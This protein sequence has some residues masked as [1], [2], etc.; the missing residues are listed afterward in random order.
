V[1]D[2][3]RPNIAVHK[4]ASVGSATIGQTFSY[5]VTASNIGDATAAAG[6][7]VEDVLPSEVDFVSANGNNG[8]TCVH[9]GS[10]SGG[11]VTCTPTALAPGE[12]ETYTIEVRANSTATTA[13]TNTA[14]VSGAVDSDAAA[15]PCIS[16][17]CGPETSVAN[18]SDSV[19][20][21]AGGPSI[22]L[23]V[24]DITDLPD[25]AEQGDAVTYTVVVTNGGTQDALA[26]DGHEVV[27]RVNVPTVGGDPRRHRR[28]AG[29]PLRG[30]RR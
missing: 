24:G 3:F 15:E 2:V 27:V 25:P 14:S 22:N 21:S 4:S 7:T 17:T 1:V 29:F 19:T 13:F 11:T 6:W 28:H 10:A 16:S 9:D 8:G 5:T 20:V 26:A 18:N 23:V 12:Q 30:H